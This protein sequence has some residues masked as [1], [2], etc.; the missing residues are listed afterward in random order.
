MTLTDLSG[1]RTCQ[2]VINRLSEPY[3]QCVDTT[4]GVHDFTRNVYE[5]LYPETLYSLEV[6]NYTLPGHR[7]TRM[8]RK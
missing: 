7:D 1:G 2:V 8:S 3:D 5:E 6:A 4:S